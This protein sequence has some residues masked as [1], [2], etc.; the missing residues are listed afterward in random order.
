VVALADV[1]VVAAVVDSALETGEVVVVD[2]AGSVVTVDEVLPEVC[3]LS[4]TIRNP[5]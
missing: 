2:G 4:F 3:P 5:I 1:V